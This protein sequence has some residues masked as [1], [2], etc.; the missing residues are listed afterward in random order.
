MR[1][2][3]GARHGTG[4]RQRASP[5]SRGHANSWWRARASWWTPGST[6]AS[7]LMP[8]AGCM[9]APCADS[10]VVGPLSIAYPPLGLGGCAA[11]AANSGRA[12]AAASRRAISFPLSWSRLSSATFLRTLV[13]GPGRHLG[14]QRTGSHRKWPE[15]T[16][17][18]A[19]ETLSHSRR[20]VGCAT[21]LWRRT[22]EPPSIPKTDGQDSAH[23]LG[24]PA[25]IATGSPALREPTTAGPLVGAMP[26]AGWDT[27]EDRWP[28]RSV[29]HRLTGCRRRRSRAPYGRPSPCR[30]R[31][32]SR[33]AL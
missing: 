1:P 9:P 16:Q 8:A 15:R 2:P 24:Q 19:V 6:P 13:R 4:R 33:N 32:S 5:C 29:N 11:L 3:S 12:R 30:D 14:P 23:R 26:F 21:R 28:A 25:R 17:T 27:A 20:K 7:G 10:T 31:D 18:V 22:T